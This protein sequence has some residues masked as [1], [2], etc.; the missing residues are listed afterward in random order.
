MLLPGQ[1]VTSSSGG[2]STGNGSSGASSRTGAKDDAPAPHAE[3]TGHAGTQTSAGDGGFDAGALGL[4]T[5]PAAIV[6]YLTHRYRGVGEK[7]AESLVERFGADLF[8]T[9]KDDPDAIKDAVTPKR[10]EQVLEAWAVDFERRSGRRGGAPAEQAE[11]RGGDRGRRGGR[12]RGSK[13][14]G[15]S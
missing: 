15:E 8:R 10:A 12:R 7:T 13:G 3:P 6:R 1:A 11:S 14:R 2:R 5:E 9:L 4:P